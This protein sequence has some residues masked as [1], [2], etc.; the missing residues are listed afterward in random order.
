MIDQPVL[1]IQ[2]IAGQ[3]DRRLRAAGRADENHHHQAQMA[4]CCREQAGEFGSFQRSAERLAVIHLDARDEGHGG[5]LAPPPG[6][7]RGGLADTEDALDIGGREALALQMGDEG[8][9][10]RRCGRLGDALLVEEI[11]PVAA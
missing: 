2:L 9:K 10:L 4:G 8:F 7:L 3:L 11:D 1:E 5:D 6:A